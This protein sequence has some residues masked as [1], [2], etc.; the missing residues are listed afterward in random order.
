MIKKRKNNLGNPLVAIAA[1]VASNVAS[2]L[3]S[4]QV[5]LSG[6]FGVS[7]FKLYD[8]IL[9]KLENMGGLVTV[10][11][12]KP[13]ERKHVFNLEDKS[14]HQAFTN[15]FVEQWDAIG[16]ELQENWSKK[17]FTNTVVKPLWESYVSEYSAKS[18]KRLSYSKASAGSKNYKLVDNKDVYFNISPSQP[19][20]SLSPNIIYDKSRNIWWVQRLDA[21]KLIVKGYE[22][23]DLFVFKTKG[24][25][26]EWVIT[27]TQSGVRVKQ[28]RTVDDAVD[29]LIESLKTYTSKEKI[30]EVINRAR[31]IVGENPR[32]KLSDPKKQPAK[33]SA[34]PPKNKTINI[35][36]AVAIG[37]LR[38]LKLKSVA[39]LGSADEVTEYNYW[40]LWRE[41]YTYYTPKQKQAHDYLKAETYNFSDFS[42]LSKDLREAWENLLK[43]A[44]LVYGKNKYTT[45][46]T[47]GRNWAGKNYHRT[48]GLSVKELAKLIREELKIEYPD[49]KFSVTSDYNSIN[50]KI[51]DIGFNPFTAEYQK[52]LQA[53]EK[54]DD[55]F[56]KN[57]D[58]NRVQI[59][60]D[61]AKKIEAKV[62]AIREQYNYDNSDVM[63]DYFSTRYYGNA[64]IDKDAHKEKY[65]PNHPEVVSINQTKAKWAEIDKKNREAAQANKGKYPRWA[66]MFY[67]PER[68]HESWEKYRL[69]NGKFLAMITKSPNGRG[70]FSGDYNYAFMKEATKPYEG[71]EKYLKKYRAELFGKTWERISTTFRAD[72]EVFEKRLEPISGNPFEAKKEPAKKQDWSFTDLPED[73]KQ[74]KKEDNTDLARAAAIARLRILKLK[75]K[76]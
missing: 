5:G 6:L 9:V 55:F 68:V 33:R 59:L 37:R 74:S 29:S 41:I 12:S 39:G 7:S 43:V 66:V 25:G 53:G 69:P 19:P 30:L 62:E 67:T 10:E 17:E 26:S 13:L 8:T 52:S 49:A 48:K 35:A 46:E 75:G 42:N 32:N 18:K 16:H 54:W 28:G 36:R 14:A 56:E 45:Q 72:K 61:R 70:R 73:K 31:Q 60:N 1:G 11:F 58:G 34:G 20:E 71:S 4:K 38:I 22:Y 3:I 40:E 23:L 47:Y 57:A 2:K 64:S 50:V 65:Y 44:N 24:R 51:V 76:K 27:E 21:K 15:A 63:T